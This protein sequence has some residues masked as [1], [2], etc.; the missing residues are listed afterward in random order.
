MGQEVL[1]Q[2]DTNHEEAILHVTS[3]VQLYS[4]YVPLLFHSGL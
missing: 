2:L 1:P 4:L 3:R